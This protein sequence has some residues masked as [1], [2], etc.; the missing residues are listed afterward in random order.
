MIGLKPCPSCTKDASLSDVPKN[1]GV[2]SLRVSFFLRSIKQI[3][4][5]VYTFRIHFA[6][7]IAC[8]IY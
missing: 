6:P 8:S 3:A 5:S 7:L 2:L 1:K 4:L